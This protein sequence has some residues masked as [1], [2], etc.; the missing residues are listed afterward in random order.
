VKI[1]LRWLIAV[2]LAILLFH[3]YKT[4][5]A[6]SVFVPFF[7][8]GDIDWNEKPLEASDLN[9]GDKG[10]GVTS[11]AMVLNYYGIELNPDEPS[12]TLA[13]IREVIEAMRHQRSNFADAI[14][15]VIVHFHELLPDCLMPSKQDGESTPDRVLSEMPGVNGFGINSPHLRIGTEELGAKLDEQRKMGIQ[16]AREEIPWGEVETSPGVFRWSYSYS[17]TITRDFDLLL[18]E[19]E[20]RNIEMLA[21]LDYGPSYI[22]GNSVPQDQLLFAWERYVK[23]VVA[24]FGDRV[25]Y[26]EIGNEMNSR[27]FWGKVVNEPDS[28]AEPNPAL[29]AQMLKIAFTEIKAHDVN[30]I[31]ILGG[32]VTVTDGDCQTNP[33][34]YLYRLYAVDHAAWGAFD[35]VALHPYWGEHPPEKPIPRGKAHQPSTG[36]CIADQ[37]IERSLLEEVRAFRVLTTQYGAKPVW[38][39]EIGWSEEQLN[40]IQSNY[41]PDSSHGQIE[42]DYLARTYVPLLS[43]TEV[44]TVIWYS[45][46]DDPNDTSGKFRLDE[47]GQRALTNLSALLNGSKP[48]G[49]FQG[50]NDR[51]RPDDDDVYEYRFEKDDQLII[52][53]WKARGDL[54]P[55]DVTIHNIDVTTLNK[56]VVYAP[57][58]S[59][60][61]GESL[62]VENGEV[63]IA[64]TEHPVILISQIE[65]LSWWDSLWQ[66][67]SADIGSWWQKQRDNFQHQKDNTKEWFQDFLD[68]IINSIAGGEKNQFL[69]P[70]ECVRSYIEAIVAQDVNSVLQQIPPTQRVAAK[71]VLATAFSLVKGFDVHLNISALNYQEV[72][73]DGSNAKVRVFGDVGISGSINQELFDDTVYSELELKLQN[74][75]GI[76]YVSGWKDADELL[77]WL[78]FDEYIP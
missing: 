26:W 31:V 40:I 34:D 12:V 54:I 78:G 41:R 47:T 64:L 20:K 17:P 52:V 63:T 53:I 22:V 65:K 39:T 70:E 77:R 32:L 55:R 76:W 59:S 2:T 60:E 29:Y 44:E 1:L 57:E 5:D 45:Q 48:L 6:S 33:F 30:D 16:F 8:Q 15:E 38:I 21:L 66:E 36:A 37:S 19:L 56:Y 58:I 67:V 71:V 4:V 62:I 3:E 10:C 28:I 69:T 49:Q 61:Y 18:D 74:Y 35:A 9:I 50:Q 46:V 24:Q 14:A 51:N 42:A 25:D 68:K 11:A 27:E 7:S 23:A 73:N 72:E 13:F 75:D 43:E